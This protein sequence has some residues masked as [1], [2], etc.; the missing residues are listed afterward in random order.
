MKP[1]Q[2][3]ILVKQITRKAAIRQAENT[4]LCCPP[5]QY[6]LVKEF[7]PL[8]KCCHHL[9]ISTLKSDHLFALFQILMLFSNN[10]IAVILGSFLSNQ[11]DAQNE[12][13][14]NKAC[15]CLSVS[16]TVMIIILPHENSPSS[17]LGYWCQQRVLLCI[18]VR[19]S[20]L[21]LID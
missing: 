2:T 6:I 17:C 18:S 8:R 7:F 5:V 19:V 16:L 21:Y 15:S 12:K 13:L 20:S 3:D 11:N 14:N 9:S 4:A 10:K 1:V